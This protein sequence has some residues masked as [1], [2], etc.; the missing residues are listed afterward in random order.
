M[1]TA[2]TPAS[3]PPPSP[4]SVRV[5]VVEDEPALAKLVVKYLER[6]AY[7]VR[8]A[9]DGVQ[10]LAAARELDPEV[11][12]LDLGLPGMDGVEVCRELR[13]FSDCYVLMLTARNDEVDT[14]VGLSVGADDYMTKPF[15]PRELLARITVLLRRPRRAPRAEAVYEVLTVGPLVIDPAAREVRLDG[16]EVALTP[17]EFELLTVLAANPRTVLTRRRLVDHVW[18]DRWVG[19][20]RM[21]DVH[22]RNLRRKLGDDAT[23][24][25]FVRTIRGVGYRI[26]TGAA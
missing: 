5:L 11:V 3:T 6:D 9:H 2:A 24:P 21:V 15:S 7:Q 12:I 25:R 19:D 18:G 26:G 1:T 22:V 23:S 16:H 17:T 4:A 13:T 10:G 14:L 20:E 8:V